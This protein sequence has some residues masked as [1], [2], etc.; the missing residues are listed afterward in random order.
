MRD[1]ER[2]N[3]REKEREIP[4]GKEHEHR[5]L[6]QL[7]DLQWRAICDEGGSTE[8]Q[9]ICDEGRSAMSDDDDDKDKQAMAM[10]SELQATWLWVWFALY[11]GLVCSVLGLGFGLLC[12]GVWFTLYWDWGLVCFVLGFGLLYEWRDRGFD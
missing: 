2:E 7:Y 4:W 6:E 11:W 1:W 12:I 8:H 3:Q 10:T 5:A 9:A